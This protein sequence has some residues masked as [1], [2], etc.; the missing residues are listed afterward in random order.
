[1]Q[2]PDPPVPI[3][4]TLAVGAS[5]LTVTFDKPLQPGISVAGNWTGVGLFGAVL[6]DFTPF[7]NL[8]IAGSTVAGFIG[9]IPGPVPGP[10]RISYAAA[11]ADV[12]ALTG[13]PVTAFTDFPLTM[14]P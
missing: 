12:I 11:P 6:N 14:L 9:S 10:T 7:G 5:I 1:M 4:A 8:T 2:P 3:D 13:E